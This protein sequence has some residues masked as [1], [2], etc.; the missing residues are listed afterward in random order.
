MVAMRMADGQV[1]DVAVAA[2]GEWLDMFQRCISYFN[3]QFAHPAW[4]IAV[5]LP[6]NGFVH[7]QAGVF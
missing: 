3:V 5:Q 6:G 1:V 2:F 7:F 4:H